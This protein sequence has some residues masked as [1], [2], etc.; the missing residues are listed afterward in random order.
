MALAAAA[1][2]E[3]ALFGDPRHGEAAVE[4]PLVAFFGVDR[5]AIPYAP[6]SYSM[7]RST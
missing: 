6:L 7:Q 5:S 1:L 2:I 3:V 4:D